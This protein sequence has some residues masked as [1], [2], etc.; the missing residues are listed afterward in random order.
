MDMVYDDHDSLG[1]TAE[2]E[3]FGFNAARL[4]PDVYMNELLQGMRIIHQVLPA[5]MKKLGMDEKDFTLDRSQ[6]YVSESSS[7][8]ADDDSHDEDAGEVPNNGAELSP[9]GKKYS[10]DE[11][12]S[13]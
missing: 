2:A 10:D 11:P 4:H 1:Q 6:L 9:E 13:T 5:I 12:K 8:D 7:I 3:A